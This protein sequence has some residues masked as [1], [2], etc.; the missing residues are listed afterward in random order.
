M[1]PATAMKATTLTASNVYK[2]VAETVGLKP[3]EVKGAVEAVMGVAAGE[4]KKHGSFELPGMLALKLKKEPATPARKG[5]N[6]LSREMLVGWRPAQPL[7][8]EETIEN[9]LEE[10]QSSAASAQVKE[11]QEA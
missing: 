4:L 9:Q 6:Q 3:K 1:A 8:Q 2:S 5:E 11:K 7:V 10:I